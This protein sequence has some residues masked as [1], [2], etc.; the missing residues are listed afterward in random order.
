VSVQKV[1]RQYRTT[2]P[3][4]QGTLKV[5]EVRHAR[6]H[7]QP[8]LVSRFGGIELHWQRQAFL[9]DHPKAV[10][11]RRSEVVQ[12][13]LAQVCEL[14]GAK[15]MCEVYH[16]RQLADLNRPG[17]RAKPLWGR[18]M[19]ARQRKTLVVCRPCHEDIHRERPSRHKVTA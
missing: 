11:S 14:C 12:R 16:I 4:P 18:R 15:D 5:L 7:G 19:A 17:R 2:V 10:F 6:G 3:M 8:P 1:Y 13:L 9:N